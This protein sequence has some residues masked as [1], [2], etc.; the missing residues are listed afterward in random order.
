[1]WVSSWDGWTYASSWPSLGSYSKEE[2]R[3]RDRRGT[4][5]RILPA[6]LKPAWVSNTSTRCAWPCFFLRNPFR[7]TS[8]EYP[9]CVASN[10]YERGVGLSFA[11]LVQP[12][13]HVWPAASLPVRRQYRRHRRMANEPPAFNGSHI[14]YRHLCGRQR[15]TRPEHD[16]ET[17]TTRRKRLLPLLLWQDFA[18]LLGA[19]VHDTYYHTISLFASLAS[20]IPPLY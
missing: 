13:Q 20:H 18:A 17:S 5:T 4:R 14:A 7:C 3:G 9:S 10:A 16:K 8:N 2:D 15:S 6:Q 11:L 12:A 19:C 1:M